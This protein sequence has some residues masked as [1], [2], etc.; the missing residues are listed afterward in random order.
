LNRA[1]GRAEI[2]AQ[3]VEYEMARAFGDV[4][5]VHELWQTLGFGPAIKRAL[6]SSRRGFDEETL[7][8]AIVF[9]RLYAPDS[10]LGCLEWL[11]TV[12][13]PAMPEVVSP[14]ANCCVPWMP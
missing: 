5:A 14:M 10:K 4:H 8:R 9:N 2:P 3:P 12:T 13:I 6:R 11:E 1:L 7:V